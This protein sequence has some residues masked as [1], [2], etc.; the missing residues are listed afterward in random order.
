MQTSKDEEIYEVFDN[1]AE[2]YDFAN[3]VFT[4]GQH[5][6]WKQ[7]VLEYCE[8]KENHN[9]LD[10]AT[11][12]GDLAIYARNNYKFDFNIYATDINE[13]MLNVFHKKNEKHNL[14]ISITKADARDLPYQEN[15]FDSV[16]IAYGIRNIPNPEICL[17][18]IH[19]ILKNGGVLIILETGVP[20]GF[21]KYPYNF[22]VTNILPFLGKIITK[23]KWAYEYLN[24]TAHS[25]PYGKT[26][27]DLTLS[28]ANFKTEKIE[29]KLFGASYIYKFKAVK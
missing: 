16:T 21:V 24:R 12:T 14:N 20:S 13:S 11:G 4:F 15:Y 5:R 22:Y 18:D 28:S 17:K 19:R 7:K 25:F 27:A 3:D 26:F 6:I 10:I 1:I 2:K 29:K 23:K 8:F 9:Y